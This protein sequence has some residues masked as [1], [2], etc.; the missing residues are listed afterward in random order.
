M[1][2]THDFTATFQ[3]GIVTQIDASRHRVRC[4]IP[5]LEGLETDWLAVITPNAGGNQFYCLPD[6]GELVALLLD[7]R[8]ENG[9]VLGAIYNS[10]DVPP[11]ASND[12]WKK[13]FTNGTTIEHSRST[14]DITIHTANKV[15]VNSSDIQVNDGSIEINNGSIII[16][17]GGLSVTGGDVTADGISLKSHLHSGVRSGSSNTGEPV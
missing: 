6:I 13:V 15:I 1:H 11:A 7:C 17:N 16:N 9:C 14:G 4:K 8:G 12:V 2:P 10:Q 3:E 5:A